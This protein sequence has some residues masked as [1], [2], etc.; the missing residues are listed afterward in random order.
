MDCQDF[1][2]LYCTNPSRTKFRANLDSLLEA[3]R[4]EERENAAR[5]CNSAGMSAMNTEAF[6]HDPSYYFGELACRIRVGERSS[7]ENPVEARTLGEQAVAEAE[8]VSALRQ[9]NERLERELAWVKSERD[10]YLTSGNLATAQ[11]RELAYQLAQ[12]FPR[13]F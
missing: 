13:L 9:R 6:A 5:L 10:K 2:L 12:K 11:A 7:T 8:E 3:T 1:E 4:A